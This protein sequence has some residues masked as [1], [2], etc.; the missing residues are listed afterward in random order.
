MGRNLI[1]Y[2]CYLPEF[3]HA[4]INIMLE[5]DDSNTNPSV[6]TSSKQYINCILTR[7]TG[8]RLDELKTCSRCKYKLYMCSCASGLTDQKFG[9]DGNDLKVYS[10]R[11]KSKRI[12]IAPEQKKKKDSLYGDDSDDDQ[13]QRIGRKRIGT[14]CTCH[15][16]LLIVY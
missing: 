3:E 9:D 12:V 16:P 11:F 8:S 1:N 10:E 13:P 2:L 7:L 15:A 4:M 14:A 5:W 6:I